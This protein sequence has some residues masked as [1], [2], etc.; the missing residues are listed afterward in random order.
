MGERRAG[1]RSPSQKAAAVHTPSFVFQGEMSKAASNIRQ[2][3]G[4][5]G[6]AG[7]DFL[8]FP[9]DPKLCNGAGWLSGVDSH[10]HLAATVSFCFSRKEAG[11]GQSRLKYIWF[12]VMNLVF[13]GTCVRGYTRRESFS[14]TSNNLHHSPAASW[15]LFPSPTL[16]LMATRCRLGDTS[17]SILTYVGEKARLWSL[18]C[19]KPL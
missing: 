13:C 4:P 19:W 16:L 17:F 10:T 3:W 11:L 9:I 12:C 5:R 15:L 18:E 8:P 6:T 2:G 1:N 14:L 7:G